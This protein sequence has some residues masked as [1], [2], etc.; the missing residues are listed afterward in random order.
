[1]KSKRHLQA[2]EDS[3]RMGLSQELPKI[4]ETLI[5]N[6]KKSRENQ[7]KIDGNIYANAT[8]YTLP[9]PGL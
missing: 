3:K 7:Y 8:G 5:K 9:Y 6:V 2:I 1:M 4:V